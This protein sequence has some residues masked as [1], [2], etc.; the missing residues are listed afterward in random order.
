[1][2]AETGLVPVEPAGQKLKKG[3]MI[4]RYIVLELLGRGGMG[5]VY[6]AFDPEL[7]RKIA[8]KLLHARG[9]ANTADGRARLLR[10]AQAIARLS[11]ANVVVVFDVGTFRDSVFIAMEFVEG[12]TLGYWI[13]AKKRSWREVLG[14]YA[15]AGRG[16]VAAHA[17][18]LVHR[19]FK[20]DNVM[21]T[22]G[23]EVRVMD[24]GLARQQG[25]AD[26]P[27]PAE[28]P[29]SI[30]GSGG[31]LGLKLTQ[32][33]TIMG[34]PAF[35]APEQFAA[36]PGD[37][38]TDQFAFCVALYEAVYG[39]RPFAGN[40]PVELMSNVV[41]GAITD[42]PP[43]SRV[44]AWI[45]RIL[46]RGLATDPDN[47][48]PS[49]T[50]LLAALGQDPAVRRRRWLGA[51]AGVGVLAAAAVGALRF[52]ASQH[53]I[54]AGGPDRADAAW[55]RDRRGAIERALV[56]TGNK[57]AGRVFAGVSAIVDE[58]VGRWT[59]MY[60]ET[61]E[62]TH[63]RGE[64]SAEVLDLRM[65]CLNGRLASVRALGDVLVGADSATVDNAV[66]AASALPPLD[67]CADTEMLRAVVKPPDN[68]VVRARV[69]AVR[70]TTAKV[71][72]LGDAGQCEKAV[73]LGAKATAE[74]KA[75]G[76]LPAQ[77][78]AE[79]ASGRL[80]ETCLDPAK[81]IA[82]ME[83]AAAATETSRDD[84]A[85]VEV[86]AMLA[87]MYADRFHDIPRARENLRDS[88]AVLGRIPGH[89]RLE[90][91]VDV[92]GS[93]IEL[94][95]GNPEGALQFE[96][97]AYDLRTRIFNGDN[98]EL[99]S[100]LTNLGI[101]LHGLGRD[102]EAEWF[103]QRSV[104][105]AMRLFGPD[106][107]RTAMLLLNHSEILTAVGRLEEAQ[108][109]IETSLSTWRRQN[110]DRFLIGYALLD[111]GRIQ[112]ARDDAPRAV[113]TLRQSLS[114]LGDQ[115]LA[116][117]AQAKFA[118]ARAL[119]T[120]SPRSHAESL[121][122]ARAAHELAVQQPS[123]KRLLGEIETW[124]AARPPAKGV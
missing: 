48:F 79:F 77:A 95:D 47:R 26:E 96:Q 97:H 8:V 28:V 56:G 120:A 24:F 7:D 70:E 68:P 94:N 71:K 30:S 72:A 90:A 85:F 40:T 22:K 58:Y 13:Q 60:R 9:G 100:S 32:T 50:E 42:P 25:A 53:A 66:A 115:D 6:A 113:G 110:A 124:Q 80:M 119:W 122:L 98:Y 10:E 27:L 87:S 83:E 89:K 82:L 64:Q 74:A 117:V 116:A 103:S 55:G 111:V 57:S 1:M 20:P 51:A 3:A 19:D 93:V 35:M 99:T 102:S 101:D 34:T 23:G 92:A 18:G 73:S 14:V 84:Q 36:L 39:R 38:R 12:Y 81:G 21:I 62:A 17:A 52:T 105:M 123:T 67:R 45:R 44:P 5:E 59:D 11:H 65:E 121:D 108:T 104:D 75:I 4:G 86:S 112:L 2:S 49:M 106:S 91:W 16:L 46:V 33:G 78:E 69:A 76:Y 41:A 109:A 31:Y 118:L 88:R 54:C 43:D 63:V 37:A 29:A 107:T 15:A 61:C 114:M